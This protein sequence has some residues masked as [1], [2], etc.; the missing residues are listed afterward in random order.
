MHFGD[1]FDE[2]HD[3]KLLNPTDESKKKIPIN[4]NTITA[5][6]AWLVH[7]YKE[8]ALLNVNIFNNSRNTQ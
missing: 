5:R 3:A 4:G 8:N 2:S 1:P 6:D 7:I